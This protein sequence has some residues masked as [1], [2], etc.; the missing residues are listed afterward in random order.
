MPSQLNLTVGNAYEESSRTVNIEVSALSSGDISGKL[1]VW[2]VE[3]SIEK[4]QFIPDGS[5]NLKYI[6][7]HVFRATI[8][9]AWGDDIQ[10][11]K[12]NEL[13]KSYTYKLDE[14]WKPE[15]MA[16]VAF[17]YD[18]NGVIQAAQTKLK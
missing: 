8:N 14:S 12:E 5:R 3:S 10:L 1:Q 6:H 16:V 15:N 7:N 17:I 18:D 4:M 11:V 9:G 13:T 2:L